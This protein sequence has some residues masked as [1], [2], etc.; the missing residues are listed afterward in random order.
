MSSKALWSLLRNHLRGS[1]RTLKVRGSLHSARK[2]EVFSPA[3]MQALGKQCPG[4]HRLCLTETDLRSLPYDCIPST[5]TTLELSCCEIA[6]A[7]FQVP[8]ASPNSQA[9][10][11]IQHLVIRNVPAFSN[12]HLLNVSIQGTL[13]TLVLS[14]AYRVTDVGIQTAAPHLGDL[15]LLAL[16][17]CSIGDSATHFIG[18]HMK[19][20]HNLDL[21]GSPSL[22]DAGL[23]CLTSLLGLEELGLES[24][25]SLSPEAI[26]AVCQALPQLRHIDLSRIAFEVQMIHK[27]QAGLPKCVV[28]N[29][30]SSSDSNAESE[31]LES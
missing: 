24:C 31:Q 9:F 2:Q 14:E 10:P 30:V 1:L 13:K 12:Q 19:R 23:A 7:W 29:T 20:L 27:I 18:R 17:Q 28:T 5:L 3:L 6:S 15:E 11:Q 21:G 16:R 26:V 8:A 22:T 4:L 25:C